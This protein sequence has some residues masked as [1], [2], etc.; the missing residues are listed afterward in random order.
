M[1]EPDV[2]TNGMLSVP[3]AEAV[4]PGQLDGALVDALRDGGYVIY[5]RHAATDRAQQDSDPGNLANCETQRNLTDA[6]RAEARA[7]GEGIRALG[8]PIGDVRSSEYCRAKEH[9]LLAFDKA[10]VEPSLVLPDPL[11]AAERQQNKETLQRLLAA[12]PPSG[13]NT[14]LVSHSPNLKEAAQIDLTAEGMAAILRPNGGAPALV[15]LVPPSDWTGAAQAVA[16]R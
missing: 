12:S 5:F 3:A 14:V 16:A 13:T 7:M 11:P 10:T 15:A 8:I 4:A 9:A 1:A 6:G 2:A